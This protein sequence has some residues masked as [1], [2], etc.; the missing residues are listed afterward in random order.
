M[1]TKRDIDDILKQI[2]ESQDSG[3]KRRLLEEANLCKRCPE[4]LQY[5]GSDCRC[6][7]HF[8]AELQ[9][10]LYDA[11]E[12]V[13]SSASLEQGPAFGSENIPAQSRP[14]SIPV[15]SRFSARRKA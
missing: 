15:P 1:C 6:R 12:E 2:K 14:I 10:Y 11:S 9:N 13:V 8:W 3:H 7:Q 5:Y 4:N